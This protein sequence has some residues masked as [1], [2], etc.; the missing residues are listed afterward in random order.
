MMRATALLCCAGWAAATPTVPTEVVYDYQ[1]HAE[2]AFIDFAPKAGAAGRPSRQASGTTT[3]QSLGLV[4]NDNTP[5][6]F[7]RRLAKVPQKYLNDRRF[8]A[9]LRK[10]IRRE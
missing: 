2:T 10:E 1:E 4:K 7:E 8:Q 5:L 6:G 3:L 9:L